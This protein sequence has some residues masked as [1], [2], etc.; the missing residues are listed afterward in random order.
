MIPMYGAVEALS[1]FMSCMICRSS[2]Y[3]TVSRGSRCSC[4]STRDNGARMLRSL[5]SVVGDG[6]VLPLLLLLQ[7]CI[8]RPIQFGPKASDV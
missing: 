1:V 7:L 5:S 2:C 8:C 4:V 3:L 6:A